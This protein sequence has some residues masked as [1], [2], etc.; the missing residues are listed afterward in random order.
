MDD[1]VQEF[2]QVKAQSYLKIYIREMR[3]SYEANEELITSKS[4][5]DSILAVAMKVCR[6]AVRSLDDMID[7]PNGFA[8]SISDEDWAV[9]GCQEPKLHSLT[10]LK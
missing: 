1:F 7:D 9:L 5:S 4:V 10:E 6:M 3:S 8:Q 2:K